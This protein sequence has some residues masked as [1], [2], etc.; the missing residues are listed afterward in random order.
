M[1]EVSMRHARPLLLL[2]ILVV[3]AGIGATYYGRLKQQAQS[4]PTKPA[5]LPPGTIGQTHE[6]TYTHTSNQKT[7]VKVHADD[8]REV[9]GK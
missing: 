5:S 2:A 9:E 8:L 4:A 6:W 1:L 7:V 3:L